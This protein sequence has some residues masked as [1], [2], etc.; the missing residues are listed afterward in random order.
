M[1][2]PNPTGVW[3]KSLQSCLILYKLQPARL[4]WPWNYPGKNVRVGC[5]ALLQ[6]IFPTQGLNPHLLCPLHW[7]TGSSPLMPPGKPCPTRLVSLKEGEN[8]TGL[9]P[10]RSLCLYQPRNTRN[11]QKT[12]SKQEREGS[13]IN[14]PGESLDLGLPDSKTMTAYIPVG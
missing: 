7:Q 13:R 4:I 9:H 14:S 1:G 12:R 10:W 3:A 2:G 5:C 11:C 6:G 8:W